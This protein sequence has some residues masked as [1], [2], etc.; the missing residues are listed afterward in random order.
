MLPVGEFDFPNWSAADGAFEIFGGKAPYVDLS[1]QTSLFATPLD[2]DDLLAFDPNQHHYL[3]DA[4]VTLFNLKDPDLK[5]WCKW[6]RRGDSLAVIT[7]N[8][9]V[10]RGDSTLP[11]AKL[12]AHAQYHATFVIQSLRSIPAMMLRRETFP[13]FIHR[14]TEMICSKSNG[15]CL[16]EALSACMSIA[17]LFAARTYET[18]PFLWKTIRSQYRHFTDQVGFILVLSFAMLTP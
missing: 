15:T 9:V 5:N 18:K 14:H 4:P 7:E 8:P 10:V 17:Q 13:W 2:V 11:A 6:T 12:P 16:P 1:L 3:T